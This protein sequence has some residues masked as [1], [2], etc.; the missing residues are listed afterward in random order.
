MHGNLE[1]SIEATQE[2]LRDRL[3]KAQAAHALAHGAREDYPQMDTFLA[4]TARH[5]SAVS[6][7]LLPR[8][9]HLLEDGDDRA[10]AFVQQSRRL[11][12]AMAQAKAKLYGEAHA[13]HRTWHDV[14]AD[15][16]REFDAAMLMESELIDDLLGRFDPAELDPLA[17]RLY[18]AELHGPT[19]PH[20]YSPHHGLTGKVA[21]RIL[22]TVD[23]FWDNAEG[24]MIPEPPHPHHLHDGPVTHYLLADVDPQETD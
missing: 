20:P 14:W 16:V 19:R 1:I 22:T 17:L 3:R 6:A 10:R 11:E 13:I 7:V 9:R 8:A 12:L 4:S 24:R 5:V 23:H 15:V 2:V 21:R 18:H